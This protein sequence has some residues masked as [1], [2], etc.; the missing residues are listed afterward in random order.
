M[1]A[2][3][4]T[5][6]EF[7]SGGEEQTCPG[8]P[9]Q[10]PTTTC[11]TTPGGGGQCTTTNGGTTIT[12]VFNAAGNPVTQTTC[13][14]TSVNGGMSAFMRGILGMD[15]GGTTTSCTGPSKIALIIEQPYYG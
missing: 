5:E 3:V 4:L 12:T 11:T 8:A 1:R 9:T 6:V 2:L 13:T 7:V 15:I 10:G 14:T